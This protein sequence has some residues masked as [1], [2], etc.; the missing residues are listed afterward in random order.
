MFL[1]KKGKLKK[2][3]YIVGPPGSGKILLTQVLGIFA[4]AQGLSTLNASVSAD[5]SRTSEGGSHACSI[6]GLGE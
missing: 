6:P 3:L 2:N 5:Q 1:H 4:V